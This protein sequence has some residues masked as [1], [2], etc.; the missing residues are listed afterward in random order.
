[1]SFTCVNTFVLKHPFLQYVGP[2]KKEILDAMFRMWD[3]DN[4]LCNRLRTDRFPGPDPVPLMREHLGS[5]TSRDYVITDKTDGIRVFMMCMQLYGERHV[6]LIDRRLRVLAVHP[7]SFN[8]DSY[9]G[10]MLDCELTATRDGRLQILV[11]DAMTVCG[12]SL[13]KEARLVNRLTYASDHVHQGE[14]DQHVLEL[15]WKHFFSIRD[16]LEF[17]AHYD[18]AC[19]IYEVDGAILTPIVFPIVS[20]SNSG[21]FKFKPV[22]DNTVDFRHR[23]GKLYVTE[24]WGKRDRFVAELSAPHDSIQNDAIVECRLIDGSWTFVRIR[25]D[26]PVANSYDTY[27]RTLQVIDEH[28]DLPELM[29]H[30]QPL[31]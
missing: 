29:A 31:R 10:T 6:V 24:K 14:P 8:D 16:L 17:K 21:I 15:R 4:V 18:A 1:M 22:Q 20:G 12:Q 25:D 23:E 13:M 26:K 28:L 2:E 11:F 19:T 7:I 5:L 9:L 3:P 27:V 30:V